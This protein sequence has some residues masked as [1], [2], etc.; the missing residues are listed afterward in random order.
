MGRRGPPPTP[1]PI[2]KRRGSWRAKARG[3][4]PSAPPGRPPCPACLTGGARHAWQQLAPQLEGMGVLTQVDGAALAR[5]C[6]MWDQ[7]R[8]Y[9]KVL[10]KEGDIT[11]AVDA[12]GNEQ[13][14]LRPEVAESRRLSM[15][16]LRLEK[17][18]GLTPA[19][20]AHLAQ[21][22]KDTESDDDRFFKIRA[23]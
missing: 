6:Q 10:A 16:L 12:N 7:W 1:T 2:L 23:V 18:F 4:E 20:R 9:Q 19:A 3:A 17:E 15:E 22:A 14:R 8:R 21:A 13:L 11:K 5:Y